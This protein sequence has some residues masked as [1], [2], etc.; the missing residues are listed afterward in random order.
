LPELVGV[1]ERECPLVIG[2][3]GWPRVLEWIE[4]TL[5]PLPQPPRPA[6]RIPAELIAK[7]VRGF[8]PAFSDVSTAELVDRRLHDYRSR[9]HR[10]WV[11]VLPDVN[12]VLAELASG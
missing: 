10:G 8:R 4:A 5:R 11:V 3:E 6:W 1:I 2:I 12:A 9:R 7:E